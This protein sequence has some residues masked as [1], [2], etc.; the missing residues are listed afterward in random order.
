MT[1]LRLAK[2]LLILATIGL[3]LGVLGSVC[4]GFYYLLNMRFAGAATSSLSGNIAICFW[5]V[6]AGLVPFALAIGFRAF[7]QACAER[8]I[9]QAWSLVGPIGPH[10]E[11]A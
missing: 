11:S 8:Q 7:A 1:Q 5:P 3:L 2:N 6:F 4:G 9:L 10:H